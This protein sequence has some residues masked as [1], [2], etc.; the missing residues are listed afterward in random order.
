MRFYS[1]PLFLLLLVLSG[2]TPSPGIPLS[3]QLSS[4][5]DA[6][7][8]CHALLSGEGKLGTEVEQGCDT[9]LKRLEKSNDIA[10]EL[11]T[12]K[13]RKSD[14]AIKET[15]YARQRLKLKLEY[16][17]L[18]ETVKKATLAAVR[19]DDIDA[20][21]TSVSFPGNSFIE[22]YYVYMKSK[23][24]RFDKDPRYLAYQYRESE[25]LAEKG[26]YYLDQGEKSK[27]LELFEKAADMGNAQSARSTALLY[28]ENNVSQALYWHRKAVENNVTAS[29]YNLARLYETQGE[30]EKARRWYDNAAR[31]GDARA[32]Y[33]LYQRLKG[34]EKEKALNWLN[35][36]AQ[37][38]YPEAQYDYGTFLM[39]ENRTADAISFLQQAAHSGYQPA[40]DFL[41]NYFYNLKL[42]DRA[43]A[44]L[45]QSESADAFYL[46]AEMLENARGCERDYAQAYTFYD[47]AYVLGKKEALD[48][49][50]RVKQL[51]IQEQQ[52]IA[53]EA[54]KRRAE[55]MAAMVK[56]CGEVP[57]AL[58]I[59]TGNKKFHI[60]GTASASLG[61]NTFIIYGD[62]G[63]SYYL[64]QAKGIKGGQRVDI[65][66]RSTG[67]TA[68]L[69]SADDDEPRDI[70]QFVYLKSCAATQ[71]Q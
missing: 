32:Q 64:L 45:S 26:T 10:T 15:E 67:K 14:R 59:K 50:K 60:T 9:F 24:P 11:D 13:L 70:Y 66:V 29:Q 48:D 57:T 42:Y 44:S 68:L 16:E 53:E 46:R 55:Q 37:S 22:S 27:A 25:K 18:M 43:M 40:S 58:L 51:Q 35:K 52:R 20:F 69:R 38:G 36:S 54:E 1:L 7:Q 12:E 5:A 61:R 39:E 63:E 30:Q 6:Q 8:Q 2:C 28:E 17:L 3:P 31:S 71:E 65:S 34:Q 47:K 19:E 21:T 62:D 41:G 49:A 23:S 56:E 33:K 4:Y